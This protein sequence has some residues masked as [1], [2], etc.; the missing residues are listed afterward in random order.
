MRKAAIQEFFA[1][2]WDDFLAQNAPERC[3]ESNLK[4]HFASHMFQAIAREGER[5][6]N[7]DEGLNRLVDWFTHETS[8]F[9]L[10]E[11]EQN[12]KPREIDKAEY[13]AG[14]RFDPVHKIDPVSRRQ[15]ANIIVLGG[16]GLGA[17]TGT[18]AGS[19]AAQMMPDASQQSKDVARA[20]GCFLG[21]AGGLTLGALAFQ[22][23]D[24][25]HRI[26]AMND[27]PEWHQLSTTP[28][29]WVPQAMMGML[30]D[31]YRQHHPDMPPMRR[32]ALRGALGRG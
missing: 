8:G 2:H 19:I 15:A 27:H 3:D 1:S 10:Q 28:E 6:G 29:Y 12:P 9:V 30:Q 20:M 23:A 7:R 4:R 26:K 16:L 22:V 17:G 31:Y 21:V 11:H 25:V 18:A 13:T 5:E 24:G 32:D 14:V